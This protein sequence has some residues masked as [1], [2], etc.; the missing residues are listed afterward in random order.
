MKI[1]KE[2]KDSCDNRLKALGIN[3]E[4]YLMPG[5]L[6]VKILGDTNQNLNTLHSL[7]IVECDLSCLDFF[8]YK[9]LNSEKISS[10]ILPKKYQDSFSSISDFNLL[11]LK[12]EKQSLW[13]LII[14]LPTILKPLNCLGLQIKNLGFCRD[15]PLKKLNVS[16]TQINDLAGLNDKEISELNIFKTQVKDLNG[17]NCENLEVV[18]LSGTTIESIA[19]LQHP[20]NLRD[21]KSEELK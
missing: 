13:I 12:V 5:G 2:I 14:Y 10:L 18:I 4:S 15:M 19:P 20:K 6:G 3:A 1:F 21:W 8:D 9:F 16:N 11:Q 17:L 7:P